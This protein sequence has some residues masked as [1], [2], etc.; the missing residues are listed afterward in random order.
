MKIKKIR[1][2]EVEY[3]VLFLNEFREFLVIQFS[4]TLYIPTCNFPLYTNNTI[5]VLRKNSA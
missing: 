3:T 1:T 5:I 2:S 4:E